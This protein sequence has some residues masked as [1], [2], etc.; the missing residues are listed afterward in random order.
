MVWRR[1]KIF[2]HL[3]FIRIW[4]KCSLP[5]RQPR[6]AWPIQRETTL[7]NQAISKQT[8]N[9]KL[10]EKDEEEEEK[11]TVAEASLLLIGLIK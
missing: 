5:N 6:L 8:K 2:K 9:N 3:H 10:L 7:S 4:K 11:E 1:P